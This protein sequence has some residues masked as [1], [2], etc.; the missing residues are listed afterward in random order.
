MQASGISFPL[1]NMD[2]DIPV[3][4]PRVRVYWLQLPIPWIGECTK[5]NTLLIANKKIRKAN[6]LK[7]LLYVRRTSYACLVRCSTVQYG[8]AIARC[9]AN[10]QFLKF[11]ENMLCNDVFD[12]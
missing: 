6:Q 3:P 2:A 9:T 12:R 1:S 4:S 10:N 7:L 8:T 5:V 11:F